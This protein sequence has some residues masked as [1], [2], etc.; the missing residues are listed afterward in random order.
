[1]AQKIGRKLYQFIYFTFQGLTNLILCHSPIGRS[2][3][4]S[5]KQKNLNKIRANA[6]LV[7]FL[8]APVLLADADG[9][10]YCAYYVIL[11]IR[12]NSS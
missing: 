6:I 4:F 12:P 11:R 7:I 10:Q 1:M 9:G 3:Y 8:V 2:E 5:T